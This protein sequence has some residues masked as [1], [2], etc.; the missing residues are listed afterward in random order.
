[1]LEQC[2]P[3][4]VIHHSV[5]LMRTWIELV[6]VYL[7]SCSLLM[8]K[9]IFSDHCLGLNLIVWFLRYVRSREKAWVSKQ[10]WSPVDVTMVV[11]LKKKSV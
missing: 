9:N 7:N 3:L 10:W 11:R 8:L 4:V 5:Y 6:F 1:M 2:Q